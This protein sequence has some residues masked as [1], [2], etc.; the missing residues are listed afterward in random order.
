MTG[1]LWVFVVRLI[2]REPSV[3]LG[4]DGSIILKQVVNTQ[5]DHLDFVEL[6]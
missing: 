2:V 4:E 1:R 3:G 5:G 6:S